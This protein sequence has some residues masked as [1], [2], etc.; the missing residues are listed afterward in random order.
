MAQLVERVV[1]F[2]EAARREGLLV[3]EGELNTCDHPVLF[4][5]A[6]R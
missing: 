1:S 3:L 5:G 6:P 2:A 4:H